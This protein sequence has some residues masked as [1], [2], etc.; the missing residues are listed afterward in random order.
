MA[1][2]E[3]VSVAVR[4][5]FVARQTKAKPVPALAELLWNSLDG[6]A[7]EV[8]VEFSHDDLAGGMSKIVVYDNGEGFSR[9][10]ARALFGNLGGSW[11]RYTRQTKR[12]HRMIHGQEGRGRYKAFALGQSVTWKVC[13]EDPSG[14]KAFE[15]RLLEADLTDVT[16]TEEVPAPGRATG[17]IVEIDD[18]RRDFK[19]LE[20][21]DG[22][23]DLNEIFALYLMNYRN[24]SILVAGQRLDPEKVIA[25]HHR[26][27][28]P[29]IEKEDGVQY[30]VE[31]EVIEWRTEAR[32]VLYLCSASGFPLDQVETRFQIPGFSFSA[33]LKSGYVEELHNEEHVALSEMDPLLSGAVENA[34]SAIKDYFRDRSPRRRSPVH[35]R[36]PRADP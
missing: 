15:V 35:G 22:L 30:D 12:N 21:E 19:T 36:D 18:L 28:L 4:D 14:R 33:Y 2:E 7:N 26:A 32:R 31:L 13:Y 6:D 8:S 16:I 24:V 5:D 10:D 1:G 9:S 11:K 3:H 17:V 20:S 29:S 27:T 23:Q 25:S 34:R